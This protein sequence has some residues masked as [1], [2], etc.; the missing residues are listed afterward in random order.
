LQ[1]FQRWKAY[2]QWAKDSGQDVCH[3]TLSLTDGFMKLF[4]FEY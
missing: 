1:E 2:V 3:L 4:I